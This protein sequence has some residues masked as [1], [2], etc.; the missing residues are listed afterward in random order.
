MGRLDL[1]L[2]WLSNVSSN[3]RGKSREAFAASAVYVA[4]LGWVLLSVAST[5]SRRVVSS[6]IKSKVVF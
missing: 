5:S 3:V 6:R 2:C 1:G 4:V